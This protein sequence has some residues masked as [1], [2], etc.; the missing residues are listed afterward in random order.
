MTHPINPPQRLV[1]QWLAD[2][3]GKHQQHKGGI[4]GYLAERAA[5]WGADAELQ[6]IERWFL[7][8][9]RTET[10][11]NRDLRTLKETRRPKPP[12]LKQQALDSLAKI[13]DNKATYLDASIIRQA[14]EALNDD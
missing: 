9:Y 13:V 10:W 12:S 2:A 5:Q 14:L 6:A 8:F 7:H 3:C 4:S 11:M 1:D